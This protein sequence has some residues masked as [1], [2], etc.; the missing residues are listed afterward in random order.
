MK[1]TVDVA[2]L[3]VFVWGCICLHVSMCACTQRSVMGTCQERVYSS[4]LFLP[5]YPAVRAPG[6]ILSDMPCDVYTASQPR[7]NSLFVLLL[8]VSSLIRVKAFS[9]ASMNRRERASHS[10]PICNSLALMIWCD[11]STWYARASGGNGVGGTWRRRRRRDR[12]EGEGGREHDGWD[13]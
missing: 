13:R 6:P 7:F 2:M 3:H 1:L 11:Y 10:E 9:C 12:E 8:C 5:L 4:L